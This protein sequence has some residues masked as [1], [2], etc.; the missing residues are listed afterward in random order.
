MRTTLT[1][2]DELA[3]QL[4]ET[5]RRTDESFKVV[6]NDAIRRGLRLADQPEPRLPPFV[7]EPKACGFRPGIDP[8]RLN[9]LADEL[10]M[11]DFQRTLAGGARQE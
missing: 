10:E 5:S 3:R 11:E 9:R 1:L 8:R 2:D 7:V 6:V 4:K